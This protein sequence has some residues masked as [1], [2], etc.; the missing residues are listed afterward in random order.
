MIK[1]EGSVVAKST[2]QTMAKLWQKSLKLLAF[3]LPNYLRIKNLW[4]QHTKLIIG[5]CMSMEEIPDN[6]VQFKW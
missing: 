3:Q 4:R 1:I 2:V 5:N 6:S